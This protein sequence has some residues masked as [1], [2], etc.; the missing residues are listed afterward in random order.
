MAL[1]NNH[2]EFDI[3]LYLDQSV[4]ANEADINRPMIA[5][6]F[7]KDGSRCRLEFGQAL[8]GCLRVYM[9]QVQALE[10]IGALVKANNEKV[11]ADQEAFG[12]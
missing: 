1:P 7:E 11:E 2:L 10:L 3:N 9:T 4:I 12:G 6:T 8:G 5:A